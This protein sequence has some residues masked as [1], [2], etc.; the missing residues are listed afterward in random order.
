MR[1]ALLISIMLIVI[2]AACGGGGSPVDPDPNPNPN[3]PP[4]DIPELAG[5]WHLANSA[6]PDGWPASFDLTISRYSPTSS[7]Y[8]IPL[9]AE[10]VAAMTGLPQDQLTAQWLRE[11]HSVSLDHTVYR[12]DEYFSAPQVDYCYYA[13]VHL[14][15]A[16]H[17]ELRLRYEAGGA[18]VIVYNASKL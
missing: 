12:S 18:S 3:P 15:S 7:V 2:M 9:P 1:V 14:F 13:E 16:E 17:I 6:A 10:I 5:A 8:L 4:A 11:V